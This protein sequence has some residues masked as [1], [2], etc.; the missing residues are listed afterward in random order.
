MAESEEPGG[1]TE[2]A[3]PDATGRDIDPAQ[4]GFRGGHRLLPHTADCIIEAWGPDRASCVSEALAALVESF[5]RGSGRT[6]PRS[7]PLDAPPEGPA[8]QLVSLL[9][10][11]IY[12]VDVFSVV[13]IAFHLVDTE[14]GGIAG[15]M[16]VVPVDDVEEVGPVPKA[17][18]YHEL[19]MAKERQG[20][21]RCRVL[22]DV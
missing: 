6:D 4:G 16:E 17:V 9:E 14:D 8:D 20:G 15:D 3:T 5:A 11:V 1:R 22:V 21:W 13:P 2:S 12:T 7:L 10:D 18:S 19:M